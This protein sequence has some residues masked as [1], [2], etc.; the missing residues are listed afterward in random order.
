MYILMYVYISSKLLRSRSLKRRVSRLL[1]RPPVAAPQVVRLL[2]RPLGLRRRQ[3]GVP[4]PSFSVLHRGPEGHVVV[5]G[6][7]PLVPLRGLDEIPL[8]AIQISSK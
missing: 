5:E 6:A 3:R 7:K 4:R 2:V 8:H 1:L